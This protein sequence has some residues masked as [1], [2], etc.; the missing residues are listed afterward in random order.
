MTDAHQLAEKLTDARGKPGQNAT[1][2]VKSFVRIPI[3]QRFWSKVAVKGPDD[4]WLWTGARSRDGYG[5]I[6]DGEKKKTRHA[7]QVS[8]ELHTGK[9]M[10]PGM[11]A[12]HRCDNPPCVNPAHLWAGTL[13]ENIIDAINKGRFD[14]R[15][16]WA[17]N[18]NRGRTH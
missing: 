8:I 13:R 14:M 16:V 11:V 5:Y 2:G 7:S 1:R 3:A 18:H 17:V 15:K 6:W 10:P 12:L 9:P 4:C